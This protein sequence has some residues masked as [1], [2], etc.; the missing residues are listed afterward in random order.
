MYRE[1]CK[2]SKKNFKTEYV[3]GADWDN[4]YCVLKFRR[5]SGFY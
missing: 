3:K 1:I 4:E 2:A 5:R